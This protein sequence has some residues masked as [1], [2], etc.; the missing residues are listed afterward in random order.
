[1]ANYK[2]KKSKR[3]VRCTLCTS[4]RWF[5]NA[6]GRCKSK[7]QTKNYKPTNED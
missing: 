2:R 5:G 7:Y 3:S 1:M 6:K 4:Y